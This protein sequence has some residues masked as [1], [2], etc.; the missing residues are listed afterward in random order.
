MAAESRKIEEC[1]IHEQH[2][3]QAQR[4]NDKDFRYLRLSTVSAEEKK[5]LYAVFQQ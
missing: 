3:I 5:K 4:K 2:Q 1:Q